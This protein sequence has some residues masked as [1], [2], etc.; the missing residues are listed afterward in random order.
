MVDV[1]QEIA[2]RAQKQLDLLNESILSG[3]I[4]LPEEK[5]ETDAGS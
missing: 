3:K 2:V 5:E 1:M 4:K